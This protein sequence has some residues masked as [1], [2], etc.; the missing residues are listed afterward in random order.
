M[1]TIRKL[2]LLRASMKL[3]AKKNKK[4]TLDLRALKSMKN[5]LSTFKLLLKDGLIL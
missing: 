4:N 3:Q 1:R 5:K 2:E